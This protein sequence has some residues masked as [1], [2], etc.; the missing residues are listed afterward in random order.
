MPPAADHC[1]PTAESVHPAGRRCEVYCF[2][3]WLATVCVSMVLRAIA[4]HRS[5][6][7]LA[8][9]GESEDQSGGILPGARYEHARLGLECR[10]ATDTSA[11][12]KLHADA[13]RPHQ[14][15]AR[16]RQWQRRYAP[17]STLRASEQSAG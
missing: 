8:L 14:F 3:S 7:F 15:V 9:V 4:D 10:P 2:C 12:A 5:D 6:E 1:H 17:E 13:P 16:L 11:R